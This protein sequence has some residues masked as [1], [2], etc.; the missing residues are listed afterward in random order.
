[1]NTCHRPNFSY[2][3]TMLV[4]MMLPITSYFPSTTRSETAKPAMNL[5][6]LMPVN[7]ACGTKPAD[8]TET[9]LKAKSRAPITPGF[10]A[11]L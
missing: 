8:P 5:E 3:H 1:M 7:L 4:A 10:R 9:Q 6:T 11:D 2:W